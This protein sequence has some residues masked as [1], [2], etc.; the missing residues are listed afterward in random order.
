MTLLFDPGAFEPLTETPWNE[1][2]VRDAIQAIV[3]AAEDAF[4][5]HQIDADDGDGYPSSPSMEVWGT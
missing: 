2:R 5:L 3:D 4:D 1:P